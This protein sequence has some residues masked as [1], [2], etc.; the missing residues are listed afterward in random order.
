M[1]VRY[2]RTLWLLQWS[3]SGRSH[4]VTSIL[5]GVLCDD[6]K[7]Q[8]IK[9]RYS[10]KK[11]KQEK[12]RGKSQ[13][14]CYGVGGK[15][16]IILH[17]TNVLKSCI[18]KLPASHDFSVMYLYYAVIWWVCTQVRSPV[19]NVVSYSFQLEKRKLNLYCNKAFLHTSMMMNGD[20]KFS[21][22]R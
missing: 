6:I 3:R 14:R 16:P 2:H 17:I 7:I 8:R 19:K 22:M 4:I 20:H 18:R 15:V 13:F 9:V 21:L 10:K 5:N 12:S 11:K 1:F